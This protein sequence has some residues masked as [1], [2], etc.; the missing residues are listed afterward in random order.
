M[1]SRFPAAELWQREVEVR[2][3]VTKSFP[4]VREIFATFR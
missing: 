4:A 3:N 2:A 1:S